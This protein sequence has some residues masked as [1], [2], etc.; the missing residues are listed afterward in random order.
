MTGELVHPESTTEIEPKEVPLPRW[1]V[2]T[3][4]RIHR[5]L[6]RVSGG[7][8]GL[9]TP[10][11]DTYGMLQLET[12]G[13]KTGA[14]RRV[15][16]AYFEDG[17]DLIVIPMNGW[18]EPEPAWWLNLQSNPEASVEMPGE[19]R[20]VKARVADPNER[21]RLW[22]MA[23]EGPWDADMDNYAVARGRE[24]QVVIL[25]PR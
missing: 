24:T 25:E 7:R 8:F 1:L 21:A 18:A 14:I 2:K 19:T 6:Y 5:L 16:L 17:A 20:H 23:A 22:R 10:T 15:I 9:R 3:V 11:A 4:W 12:I 13:R